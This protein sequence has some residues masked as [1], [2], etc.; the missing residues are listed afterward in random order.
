LATVHLAHLASLASVAM[1]GQQVPSPSA[2]FAKASGRFSVERPVSA[3]EGNKVNTQ[4][5][6]FL[7]LV[8]K[9][10]PNQVQEAIEAGADLRA[11]D[12]DGWTALMCAVGNN[13]DP[14]VIT[15]LLKA[16]A[17]IEASDRTCFTPLMAAAADNQNPEVIMTLLKAG[18]DAKAKDSVGE[19]AFD[20]AQDNE[21]LKD[22]D[23]LKKLEEASK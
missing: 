7:E 6:D 18:A 10:T 21:K 5:K 17:E 9:G 13:T 2:Y 22:T 16:G 19:T 1:E 15:A 20:Y 23:A 12:T 14:E 4:M 3:L 8:K 11:Q